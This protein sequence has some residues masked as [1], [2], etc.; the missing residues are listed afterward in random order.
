MFTF[1]TEPAYESHYAGGIVRVLQ[2][3]DRK[4][5]Y[6]YH[7]YRLSAAGQQVIGLGVVT[8]LQKKQKKLF[9]GLENC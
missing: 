8:K 2:S 6:E 7:F 3:K 4:L 5:Q 9:R 1:S